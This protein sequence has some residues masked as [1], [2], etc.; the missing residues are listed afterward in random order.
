MSLLGEKPTSAFLPL[1]VFRALQPLAVLALK[2]WRRPR[3]GGGD[4]GVSPSWLD[5]RFAN[6]VIALL[7]PV[8]W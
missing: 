2:T 6:P 5:P 3:A 7:S 8:R 1:S 4:G